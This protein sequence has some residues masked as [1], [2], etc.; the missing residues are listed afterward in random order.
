MRSIRIYLFALFAALL[1]PALYA[2]TPSTTAFSY[3]GQLEDS[4]APANGIFDFEFSLWDAETNGTRFGSPIL[5][6]D[7]P[8]D[9]GLFTVE[10]DFSDVAFDG[11]LRWLSIRVGLPNTALTALNPRQRVTPAPMALYALQ[12]PGGGGGGSLDSAYDFGGPGDGRSILAD[13]GPVDIQGPDGLRAESGIE[14]PTT[15][16]GSPDGIFDVQARHTFDVNGNPPAPSMVGSYILDGDILNSEEKWSYIRVAPEGNALR[17]NVGS[18]LAF[19]VEFAPNSTGTFTFAQMLLSETGDLGLGTSDPQSRFQIVGGSDATLS[20]GGYFVIGETDAT[21]LVMD[22]NEI[23]ARN[24]GA[25]STLFLN[26]DGGAVRTGSDL[27]VGGVLDIGYE[28]VSTGAPDGTTSLNALCPSGK[29]VL[30]GGCGG[31]L[32]ADRD[33]RTSAPN[34]S[35]TGWICVWGADGTGAVTAHA[36]C[37]RVN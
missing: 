14:T 1:S 2:G 22:S 17:R 30:G 20:G 12:A 33:V 8:V 18:S 32:F 35:E 31:G 6:Q 23:I 13:A 11:S 4:G 36:I 10:L 9:D 34:L 7:V 25:T 15:L 28:I 24:D 5:L 37:A 16:I 26:N 29:K 21:N 27:L 19:A 3:Q